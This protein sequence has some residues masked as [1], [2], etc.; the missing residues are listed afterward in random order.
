VT[1]DASGALDVETTSAPRGAFQDITTVVGQSYVVYAYSTSASSNHRLRINGNSYAGAILSESADA[2]SPST[3]V[4]HFTATS[5]TT[6]IY[7]RNSD[8]GTV[9]WDNVSVKLSD[10]DR[11][12]K[13]KGLTVNGTVTRTAVDVGSELVAYSG[14]SAS[15]YLEGTDASYVDTLYAMGWVQTSGVW[16]FKHGIVSASPIEGLSIVATVLHIEGVKPK[17]LIRISATTPTAEQIAKIYADERPLFQPGAACTLYGASDA[18][19]ALAHDPVTDLLHVGTS[20]GRSTF[21]GLRRVGNTTTAV[22]TAIA[23]NGGMIL[24]Q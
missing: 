16:E 1:W 21:S 20:A 9:L 24:E 3:F 13:A 6:T 11:S 7:L 12:V 14:F 4:V 15:N 2:S 8:V 5:T 23:A 19:T 22:A 10:A 18:V 17:A